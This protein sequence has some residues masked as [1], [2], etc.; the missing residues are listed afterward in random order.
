MRG[1]DSIANA[2]HARVAQALDAARGRSAAGGTR[3]AAGPSELRHLGVGRRSHLRNG[4]DAR[5]RV[6]YE[7]GARFGVLGVGM[8]GGDPRPLLDRDGEPL[9]LPDRVRDERNPLLAL[10]NLLRE[11]PPSSARATLA[12][13]ARVLRF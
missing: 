1:I 9:E 11:R 12:K 3:S 7:L 4:L 6:G 10:R 8:A 13:T 5:P 2:E